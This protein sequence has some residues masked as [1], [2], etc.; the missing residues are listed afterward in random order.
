VSSRNQTIFQE[1]LFFVP[2]EFGSMSNPHSISKHYEAQNLT[3]HEEDDQ[4]SFIIGEKSNS[5]N[6][7]SL[8][9]ILEI[10]Q[11]SIEEE[12]AS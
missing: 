1:E 3:K 5:A 8:V 12:L 2:D 11:K 6:D 7:Q 10:A 4:S 9:S